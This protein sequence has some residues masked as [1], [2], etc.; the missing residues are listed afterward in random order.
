MNE[1]NLEQEENVSS[2]EHDIEVIKDTILDYVKEKDV[3]NL[4]TLLHKLDGVEALFVMNSLSR[5]EKAVV[6]RLLDKEC[7]LFVFEQLETP[8]QK[9]LLESF[10]DEYT[11]E[12]IEDLDPDDR[13][14]LFDEMPAGVA[15][16]LLSMLSNEER[17]ITNMLMGYKPE[18]AGRLMT[19]KFISLREEMTAEEALAKV[20]VQA[21]DKETIYTLYVTDDS[22]KL[23]GVL[24]LKH[25]LIADPNA[26]IKDIMTDSV[27][28]V[29]T[30]TDQEDVAKIVKEY[31]FLAVP[32]VDKEGR[33]VGIITHDDAMDILEHEATEDIFNQ[34]GLANIKNK[35]NSRSE[36]L[37]RGRLWS[38]WKVRLPFLLIAL[39]G[40]ILA[41]LLIGGFE[42]VLEEVMIVAFFIPLIMDLGGSVG[43]Q[44]TTVFARGL[45]LGHIDTK[46]FSKHL[47]R[48]VGI[49]FSIGI[50][51]GVVTGIIAGVWGHLSSGMPLLGLAVGLA[52][53]VT[54]TIA[55]LIGFLVPFLLV[56]MKLDQVAG[57]APIITTIKD[58]TGLTTYFLLVTLFLSNFL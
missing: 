11:R 57:A 1:N 31:D 33:I 6:F 17:Q 46:K 32:V 50:I 26:K 23:D 3:V 12:V 42:E 37:V 24:S 53:M 43:T 9:E 4:R 44:S 18:T 20:R 15:K 14:G 39:I 10:T 16:K 48:E 47:L 29:A 8:L 21:N 51:V 22:K 52:L 19:P 38:V 40:G 5:K 25:L 45:A 28:K 49:G 13:A 36:I 54:V 2:D 55:S 7:A 58:I 27:I 41:A 35:E 30:D 56:K 34:A